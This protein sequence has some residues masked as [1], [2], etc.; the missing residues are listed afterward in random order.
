MPL[1]EGHSQKTISEN[2]C[3]EIEH[4]KP[5]D[6]AAAKSQSG[7][8]YMI[9]RLHYSARS[10]PSAPLKDAIAQGSLIRMSKTDER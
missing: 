9:G 5:P 10:P 4:G 1:K 8:D 6:D 7:P 2:I 3:R